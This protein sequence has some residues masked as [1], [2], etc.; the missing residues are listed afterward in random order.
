M[1]KIV[2]GQDAH[3]LIPELLI[4]ESDGSWADSGSRQIFETIDGQLDREIVRL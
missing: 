2:S 3:L 1:Q 4:A